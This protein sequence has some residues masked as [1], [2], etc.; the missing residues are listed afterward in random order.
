MPYFVKTDIPEVTSREHEINMEA[1]NGEL[2]LIDEYAPCLVVSHTSNR[3]FGFDLSVIEETTPED[4]LKIVQELGTKE[5]RTHKGQTYYSLILSERF[6]EY[7]NSSPDYTLKSD[8]ADVKKNAKPEPPLIKNDSI[9]LISNRQSSSGSEPSTTKSKYK[10][11]LFK[12][13]SGEAPVRTKIL[14]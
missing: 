3:R 4:G 11:S 5:S 10:P 13:V 9:P 2:S 7:I 1:I 12:D 8:E 6:M 14:R